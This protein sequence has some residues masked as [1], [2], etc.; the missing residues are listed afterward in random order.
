MTH[1]PSGPHTPSPP[2]G[3]RGEVAPLDA[4]SDAGREAAEALTQALAEI[5]VAI[6]QRTTTPAVDAA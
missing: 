6:W 4:D 3:P 5:Q 2:S 1:P